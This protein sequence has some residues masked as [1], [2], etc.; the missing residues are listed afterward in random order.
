MTLLDDLKLFDVQQKFLLSQ[1]ERG[2]EGCLDRMIN[3]NF[4]KN[5]PIA[6]EIMDIDSERVETTLEKSHDKMRSDTA[7]YPWRKY[8]Q[9]VD[10]YIWPSRE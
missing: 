10:S 4:M 8:W 6:D 1:R 5:S 7:L 3:V 2:R 9:S